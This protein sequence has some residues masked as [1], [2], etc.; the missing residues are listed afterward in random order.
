MDLLIEVI[1][2]K[3]LNSKKLT[4][5][6]KGNPQKNILRLFRGLGLIIKEATFEDVDFVFEL[7]NDPVVRSNS[8]NSNP[9]VFENHVKW[10]EAQLANKFVKLFVV[11]HNSI[12]IAQVIFKEIEKNY[13]D[14]NFNY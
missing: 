14:R 13:R 1:G 9:I 12:P 5:L 10:F 7:A 2:Q 3:E 4:S 8:Y 11:L 6:F